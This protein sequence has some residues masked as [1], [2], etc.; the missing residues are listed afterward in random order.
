MTGRELR[1]E[2]LLRGITILQIMEALNGVPTYETIQGTVAGAK[3]NPRVLKYLNDI[4]IDHGR[5]FGRMLVSL[6]DGSKKLVDVK[7]NEAA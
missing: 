5:T 6:E 3:R 7:K 1:A 4:G 2:L